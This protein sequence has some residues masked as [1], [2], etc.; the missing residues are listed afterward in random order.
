MHIPEIIANKKQNKQPSTADSTVVRLKA[1]FTRVKRTWNSPWPVLAGGSHVNTVGH[2]QRAGCSRISKY[3]LN[4]KRGNS[5]ME[6]LV[7][8]AETGLFYE[9]VGR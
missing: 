9:D 2:V 4:I 6:V 3:L 1:S 5:Y 7:S 8:N